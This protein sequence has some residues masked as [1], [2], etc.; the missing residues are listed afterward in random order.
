MAVARVAE[1]FHQLPSV[2]A[3]DLDRDPER[4][5]LLCLHFLQYAD[6]YDAEKRAQSDDDLKHWRGSEIMDMVVQNKYDFHKERVE[7]R[8]AEDAAKAVNDGD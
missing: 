5:S 6:A 4:L 3:R 7:A 1:T 8:R 2:V